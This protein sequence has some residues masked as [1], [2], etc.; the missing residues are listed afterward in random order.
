MTGQ[1]S[2]HLNFM[3][4]TLELIQSFDT[5]GHPGKSSW[6]QRLSAL[7]Y[8][9]VLPAVSADTASGAN[10]LMLLSLPALFGFKTD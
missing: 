6:S 4:P 9:G 8:C 7:V 1:F 2:N 5:M 3:R 10:H